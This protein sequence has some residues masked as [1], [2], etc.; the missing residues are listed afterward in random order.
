MNIYTDGA[1]TIRQVNGK[2]VRENGG[3]AWAAIDD[4]D[5]LIISNSGGEKETTN[6]RMELMAILN[7]LDNVTGDITFNCDSAYCV[8]MLK[9][10][11]WIYGWEK[12]N[13]TRGKKHEPI[14]NLDIIK[15]IFTHLKRGDKIEFVKVK[16]HSTI[17]WNNYVD[18]LAVKA[19]LSIKE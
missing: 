10:G 17:K 12:N 13:W 7:A 8:N 15:R 6:N 11:G 3:W 18:E 5:N 9:D 14:E 4:E 1:A 16:G 19:K 2:Y